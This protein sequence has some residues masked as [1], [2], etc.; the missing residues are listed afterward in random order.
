MACMSVVNV[1]MCV[2][3]LCEHV[4]MY[5]WVVFDQ[6]INPSKEIREGVLMYRLSLQHH[7]M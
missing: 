7:M 4:C 6:S 3:T 2:Y 1:H 5:N